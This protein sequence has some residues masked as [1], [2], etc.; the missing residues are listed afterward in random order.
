MSKKN[1]IGAKVLV[2]FSLMELIVA[3]GIFTLISTVVLTSQSSFNS[4]V[5]LGSLAYDIGL[6]VREA[7]VFGL[8]V[9]GTGEG[10]ADRSDFEIGYGIYMSNTSPDSYVLFADT[11]PANNPDRKYTPGEDLAVRNYSLGKGHRISSF[12]GIATGGQEYCSPVISHINIVFMRPN[13]DANITSNEI[14]H[15][16]YSSARIVVSSAGGLTRE[17]EISSTGQISVKNP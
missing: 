3:V 4:S 13:P 12:C 10:G 17:V 9:R 16:Q 1:T 11:Y 5:L 14:G 6:S 8:S 15:G 2:G 7:Q